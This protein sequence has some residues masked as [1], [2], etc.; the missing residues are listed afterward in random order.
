MTKYCVIMQG[1]SG[2][3]KTTVARVIANV[4]DAVIHSTDDLRMVDG[5]YVFILAETPRR[6][7]QNQR[8]AELSMRNG[9]NV[10]IDNTN[11]RRWEARPYV[12]MA[13]RYGYTVR[14]IR[15]TG[16]YPNEHGVS[17]DRVQKM[18]N[19]IEDLTIESCLSARPP[20]ENTQEE[21]KSTNV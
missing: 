8:N 17:D 20:W 18:R 9:I 2:S 19:T 5:K 13:L 10:I 3:G 6:H 15:C 12:E 11:I 16:E 14:F 21:S 1:A 4:I 7:I